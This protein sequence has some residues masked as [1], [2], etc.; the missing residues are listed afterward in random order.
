LALF[1]QI[2]ISQYNVAYRWYGYEEA[3]KKAAKNI[4]NPLPALKEFLKDN[5]FR[6][7]DFKVFMEGEPV[8]SVEDLVTH[9]HVNNDNGLTVE[10]IKEIVN[11]KI[12]GYDKLSKKKFFQKLAH[13]LTGSSVFYGKVDVYIGDVPNGLA[14]HTCNKYLTLDQ[15]NP[16]QYFAK[17]LDLNQWGYSD[18]GVR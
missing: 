13:L 12:R 3:I 2:D 5:K 14:I 4:G 9:F 1:Q 11:K 6:P 16:K 15:S 17:L 10:D 18:F 7:K 8:S